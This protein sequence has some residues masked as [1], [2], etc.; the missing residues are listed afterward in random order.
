[1][2]T[3]FIGSSP[4]LFA[5][6]RNTTI[7][8]RLPMATSANLAASRWTPIRRTIVPKWTTT[9]HNAV[10]SSAPTLCAATTTPCSPF[11]QSMAPT[12]PATSMPYC[13]PYDIC[14]SIVHTCH[15]MSTPSTCSTPTPTMSTISTPTI[16]PLPRL[17]IRSIRCRCSSSPSTVLTTPCSVSLAW[18]TM[19]DY[20][21]LPSFTSTTMPYPYLREMVR[22]A[23]SIAIGISICDP[24]PMG[25]QYSVSTKRPHPITIQ[26]A[27]IVS[28]N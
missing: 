24:H 27:P 22:Y 16:S 23:S 8:S 20:A 2:P 12:L 7:F 15:S 14:L 11:F 26:P 1:M 18:T 6:I 25:G 9:P 19:H 10:S 3:S 21:T 5:P 17:P 4:T 28:A 13:P